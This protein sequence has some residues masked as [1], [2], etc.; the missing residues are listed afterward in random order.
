MIICCWCYF[1]TC[2]WWIDIMGITICE[3]VMRIV[4]VD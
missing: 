3:F 4:V 1:G 2:C